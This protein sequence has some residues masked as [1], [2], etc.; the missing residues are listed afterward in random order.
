VSSWPDG[1]LDVVEQLQRRVAAEFGLTESV[2]LD[3]MRC[4]EDLLP[5][6]MDIHEISLYRKYNRCV[7][8]PLKVGDSP[9]D[10][11]LVALVSDDAGCVSTS[12]TT[13]HAL[14]RGRPE[15]GSSQP[16]VLL[17]GSYS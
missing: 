4:A 13:L 15:R 14:L 1:W 6:D 2:G 11:P 16:L 10:T 17:A 8:G 9:P 5:G 12:T 3:A 7:D